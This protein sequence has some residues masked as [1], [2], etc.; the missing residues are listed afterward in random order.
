MLLLPKIIEQCPNVNFY[1][2]GDGPFTKNIHDR[3]V[4]QQEPLSELLPFDPKL[5][6]FDNSEIPYD[7]EKQN[8][9]G[10]VCF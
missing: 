7:C 3:L 2:A 4:I 6:T 9:N 8:K 10:S 1:W 5:C